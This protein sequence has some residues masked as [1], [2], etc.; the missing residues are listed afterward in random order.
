M[1]DTRAGFGM[2]QKPGR[3]APE[4]IVQERGGIEIANVP[5][6]EAAGRGAGAG[7]IWP[8]TYVCA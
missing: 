5:A 2:F 3:V 1:P 7:S 4:T 6:A 8:S